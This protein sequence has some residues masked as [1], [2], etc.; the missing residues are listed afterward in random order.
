[1]LLRQ[2]LSAASSIPERRSTPE[3]RHGPR[4][5][6]GTGRPARSRP[7]LLRGA[8]HGRARSGARPCLRLPFGLAPRHGRR[9]HP[10]LLPAG[11]A[12]R[13]RRR[14]G[15]AVHHQR[16]PRPLQRER[17]EHPVR[18]RHLR[19]ADRPRRD[20]GAE[21]RVRAWNRRGAPALRLRADRAG[22][23]LRCGGDRHPCRARRRRLRRRRHQALHHRR[24]RRRLRPHRRADPLRGQGQPRDEPAARRNRQPGSRGSL[25]STRSPATTSPPAGSSIVTCACR[26]S[27]GS[28]KRTTGGVW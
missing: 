7:G 1:M 23:G 12:R 19:R 11:G 25:P 10:R 16:S 6:H 20:G 8:L 18:Q 5:Q 3:E 4:L 28:A 9:R 17:R 22:R 13:Q 26:R 15:R 2:H 21:T 14:A 27:A 24:T